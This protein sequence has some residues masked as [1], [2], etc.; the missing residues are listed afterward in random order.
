MARAWRPNRKPDRDCRP[1]RRT[2]VFRAPDPMWSR[3]PPTQRGFK[4]SGCILFAIL[5][6]IQGACQNATGIEGSVSALWRQ[7]QRH[8]PPEVCFQMNEV[9]SFGCGCAALNYHIGKS[10]IFAKIFRLRVCSICQYLS[11]A[12]RSAVRTGRPSEYKYWTMSAEIAD[13]GSFCCCG[14]MLRFQ[15][16]WHGLSAL[17]LIR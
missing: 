5:Y 1:V 12:S 17:V 3:Q 6:G 13:H 9:R 11:L 8:L 14:V 2:T 7:Q 16:P 15:A 10:I 4:N